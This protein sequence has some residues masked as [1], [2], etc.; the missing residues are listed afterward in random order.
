MGVV[1]KIETGKSTP[2]GKPKTSSIPSQTGKLATP[3]SKGT[4]GKSGG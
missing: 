2:D 4:S 3:K 1:S